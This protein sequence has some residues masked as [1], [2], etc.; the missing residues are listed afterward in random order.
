MGPSSAGAIGWTQFMPATWTSYGM[1]ADGDGKADPYNSVDA[2][3][4]SARLLRA[5]GAPAS[6]RR[7]LHAYNHSWEYVRIVLE[8]AKKYA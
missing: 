3:Y 2:V 8:R 7:A 5:S 1:D 4:S 6:Y